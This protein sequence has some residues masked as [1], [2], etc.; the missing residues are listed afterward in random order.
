[1]QNFV[2]AIV[3]FEVNLINGNMTSTDQY[4]RLIFIFSSNIGTDQQ[5]LLSVY[6]IQPLM[7]ICL[8]VICRFASLVDNGKNKSL[9]LIFMNLVCAPAGMRRNRKTVVRYRFYDR[10]FKTSYGANIVLNHSIHIAYYIHVV[11]IQCVN[12]RF[13]SS[14]Q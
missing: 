10:F 1:M 8:A 5:L 12:T 9:Y 11:M 2:A 7:L 14:I 4:H 13:Q 6:G 3:S